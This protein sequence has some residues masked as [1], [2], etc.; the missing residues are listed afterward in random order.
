MR[1]HE[2]ARE[3][4]L[5]DPC[6]DR[7]PSRH[8]QGVTT[9]HLAIQ[10]N[11]IVSAHDRFES[12]FATESPHVL[13]YARSRVGTSAAEDVVAETFALAW[14]KF[15]V[16]PSPARPWLLATARRITANQ[17]RARRRHIV[18]SLDVADLG[19]P[20]DEHE[21]VDRRR[22]VI[23]ALRVLPP[24]DREAVLLVTWHDLSNTDAAK[25]MDCS[26]T[27][28]NVRLH[29]ARRRLG[30]ILQGSDQHSTLHQDDPE[31]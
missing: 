28:F 21:H 29:R 17:L 15:A 1:P 6:N 9:H 5:S 13:R 25:V 30:R 11:E 26:V 19:L 10:R 23:A 14:Q 12:V 16:L 7:G 4:I 22:D 3:T 8:L 2:G 18:E 20:T 27:A 24:R 31:Y